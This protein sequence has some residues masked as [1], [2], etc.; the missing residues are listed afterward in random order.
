MSKKSRGVSK[1]EKTATIVKYLTDNN[2]K[3]PVDATNKYLK[4]YLHGMG[5]TSISKRVK[6]VA[7]GWVTTY[8]HDNDKC[9][10]NTA[11]ESLRN[12]LNG[13]KAVGSFNHGYQK[14]MERLNLDI[15]GHLGDSQD[16]LN[17]FQYEDIDLVR[18]SLKK[19]YRAAGSNKV[20]RAVLDQI[21][22]EHYAYYKLHEA[23][24][25]LGASVNEDADKKLREKHNDRIAINPDYA[26]VQAEK[27]LLKKKSNWKE[28]A[29]ALTLITGRRPTEILKTWDARQTKSSSILFDG[30][31]K[32]RD[33]ALHE[34]LEPYF[35]PV[36]TS[37]KLRLASV[38]EALDD[39]HSQMK[40]EEITYMDVLGNPIRST[41]LSEDHD[42]ND[43]QHNR[44]VKTYTNFKI[45]QELRRI[46]ET[47][48]VTCK[49]MRAVYSVLAYERFGKAEGSRKS[50]A[51]YTA[52][53]LGYGKD[54]FGATRNY[55]QVALD[56]SVEKAF[57]PNVEER[58]EPQKKESKKLLKL[59]AGAT[60]SVLA[61]KRAKSI[62][63]LHRHL[64][65]LAEEDKLTLED[66]SAG[67]LRKMVINGKFVNAAT[68]KK[69]Y[70]KEC[71]GIEE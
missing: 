58:P 11:R 59:L 67:V 24:V 66:L 68:I 52:D 15:T 32:T 16:V 27:I 71:L 53:I 25:M 19:L 64:V 8:K 50:Q 28:K 51:A 54:G 22:P 10:R 5:I 46:F 70:L 65:N 42:K 63:A 55:E 60:E 44:G 6:G 36:L 23:Y 47:D 49:T 62:H 41:V 7:G 38:I 21:R 30:Q 31:L 33:R 56:A 40:T 20:K 3:N 12:V 57:N 37:K 34:N 29:A 61:N 35:I 26:I 14:H 48:G 4:K 1:H 18:E 69:F 9:N 43:I 39:V 17:L 2:A 13:I 45:N